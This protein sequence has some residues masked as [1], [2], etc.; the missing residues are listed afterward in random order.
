MEISL[1]D[2]TSI[3]FLLE[4]Q[5]FAMSSPSWGWTG[6]LRTAEFRYPHRLQISGWIT[7][8]HSD[9]DTPDTEAEARRINLKAL[10]TIGRRFPNS[11]LDDFIAAAMVLEM[12][13]P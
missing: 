7:I 4:C 13:A 11:E 1:S 6:G 8:A 5:G 10:A 12:C 2:G 9:A 3:Q